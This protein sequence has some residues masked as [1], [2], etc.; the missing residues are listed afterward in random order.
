MTVGSVAL[1]LTLWADFDVFNPRP[2]LD[3]EQ[4]KIEVSGCRNFDNPIGRVS[5]GLKTVGKTEFRQPFG[6]HVDVSTQA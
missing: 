3:S 4:G 1:E 6:V 5:P 2:D